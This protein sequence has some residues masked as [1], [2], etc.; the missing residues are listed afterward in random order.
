MIAG[1]IGL[2]SSRGTLSLRHNAGLLATPAHLV[3]SLCRNWANASGVPPTTVMPTAA[4]FSF[5]PGSASAALM[6]WLSLVTISLG[7]PAGT[8]KAPHELASS[9]G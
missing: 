6:P 3:I 4:S 1:F 9:P 8:R 5:T 2:S 7:V